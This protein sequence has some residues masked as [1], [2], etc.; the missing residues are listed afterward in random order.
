MVWLA[1]RLGLLI[2]CVP[3]A[4]FFAFH[5]LIHD[6]QDDGYSLHDV[7]RTAMGK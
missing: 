3:E 7:I 2:K 5:V 6:I 4:L 1:V